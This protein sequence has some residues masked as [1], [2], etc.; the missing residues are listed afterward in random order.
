MTILNS[1]TFAIVLFVLIGPAGVLAQ[2]SVRL[3][4]ADAKTMALSNHPQILAAQNEPVNTNE[5]ITGPRAPF[6]PS[7]AVDLRGTEGKELPRFGAGVL[8]ATRLFNRFGQGVIF[9]QLVTDSG[10]TKNLV[11]SSRLQAEA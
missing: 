3:T 10:R 9:S 8:S 4:L 11:A 7:F 5:Q 6:F 2:T 1:T